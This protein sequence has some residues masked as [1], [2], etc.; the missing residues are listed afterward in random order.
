MDADGLRPFALAFFHSNA[1][2]AVGGRREM[3]MAI[4]SRCLLG[5]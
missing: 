1:R 4:A 5:M 3:S 2:R